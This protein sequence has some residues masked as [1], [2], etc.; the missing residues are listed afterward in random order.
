LKVTLALRP[1]SG[2]G[3]RDLVGLA[4]DEALEAVARVEG[5]ARMGRAAAAR[6]AGSGSSSRISSG[7]GAAP[8]SQAT[9]RTSR[10][11]GSTVFH[12][13]VQPLAEVAADPV[14]HELARHDELEARRVGIEGAQ[15]GRL[16]P[17]VEGARAAVAAKAGADRGPGGSERRARIAVTKQFFVR[18]EKGRRIRIRRPSQFGTG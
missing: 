9:T 10:T 18:N 17:A 4:D 6:S 7:A 13:S 1:A 2:G 3:C 8:P 14:G 15:L 16:Q 11:I 5:R 12:A